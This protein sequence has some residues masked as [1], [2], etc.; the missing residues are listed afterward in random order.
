MPGPGAD[1]E[2]IHVFFFVLGCF[3]SFN[4]NSRTN[5]QVQHSSSVLRQLIHRPVGLPA[6]I[7]KKSRE[8]ARRLDKLEAGAKLRCDESG[9][10]REAREAAR[11]RDRQAAAASLR[12]STQN[13]AE[14]SLRAAMS[15]ER[16]K[17]QERERREWEEREVA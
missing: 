1:R 7:E 10:R 17:Q 16:M 15:H 2:M 12:L 13:E 11:E 5:H 4:M 9:I 14:E 6:W 3:K 8:T